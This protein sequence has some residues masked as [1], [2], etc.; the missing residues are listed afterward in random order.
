MA[1]FKDNSFVGSRVQLDDHIFDGNKFR[2]S[3]I[4][5]G[6]GPLSFTNNSLDSVTWEFI[7][8]AARTIALISSMYQSGG[9]SRKFVENLLSTFGR[10]AEMPEKMEKGAA[11][12]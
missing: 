5:Y 8:P 2:N 11:N 4:V 1:T 3:T 10:Q 6:G 7:G 12:E 9:D